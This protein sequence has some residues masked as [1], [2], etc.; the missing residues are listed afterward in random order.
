[1]FADTKDVKEK[2]LDAPNGN[3]NIPIFVCLFKKK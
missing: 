2:Y 1:M 3:N